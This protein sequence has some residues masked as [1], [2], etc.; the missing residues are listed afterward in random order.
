[1][2]IAHISDLHFSRDVNYFDELLEALLESLADEH[3]E[4]KIDFV[5][6]TGDLVDKGGAS[7]RDKDCFDAVHTEILDK[8]AKRLQLKNNRIII[9]P[10]NHDVQDPP[11]VSGRNVLSTLRDTRQNASLT[12]IDWRI[13]E[14]RIN[15]TDDFKGLQNFKDF[16]KK[17]YEGFNNLP[18][19]LEPVAEET[20]DISNFETLFTFK[21]GNARIGIAA[22]NSAWTCHHKL[23]HFPDGGGPKLVFGDSQIRRANAAFEGKTD[24]NIALFHHPL[25]EGFFS[26]SEE[27]RIKNLLRRGKF[28]ILFCGHTHESR[29]RELSDTGQACY[30]VNSKSTFSNPEGDIEKYK[31]GFSLLDISYA[32]PNEINVVRHY[33]KYVPVKLNRFDYD[34]EEAYR[35]TSVIKVP[36][37]NMSSAFSEYL[38][39]QSPFVHFDKFNQSYKEYL[40]VQFSNMSQQQLKKLVGRFLPEPDKFNHLR[41]HFKLTLEIFWEDENH[42]RMLES[43]SYQIKSNGDAIQ[44]EAFVYVDKLM[45]KGDKSSI[46]IKT[47]NV[48]GKEYKDEFLDDPKYLGEEDD[49][50]KKRLMK[51]INKPLPVEPIYNVQRI[52]ESINSMKINKTW[53]V[54]ITSVY[55]G[56]E[57]IVK[58]PDNRYRL[59][60]FDIN[61]NIDLSNVVDRSEVTLNE[62]KFSSAGGEIKLSSSQG[63]LIPGD[64]YLIFVNKIVTS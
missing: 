61:N 44:L 37:E 26:N 40:G 63:I 49:I 46:E 2:R 1:M 41:E 19:K 50:G 56:Y 48:N 5:F 6:V 10:G 42:F 16:E 32:G 33:R 25:E 53:I 30:F 3:K 18:E 4:R 54:S 9:I 62:L 23:D 39:K 20:V 47:F 17:F 59:E 27:R 24:F 15:F 36:L 29:D 58:N 22:F 60:F 13:A 34:V 38:K 28:S 52:H 21:F 11:G 12:D 35:A 14:N 64:T 31:S 7:F 51:K 55:S 57:I 8:L 45:E 43:Q